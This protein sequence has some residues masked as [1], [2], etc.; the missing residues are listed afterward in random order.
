M[1][2]DR[3]Q[4]IKALAKKRKRQPV[5]KQKADNYAKSIIKQASHISKL[6]CDYV[7]Q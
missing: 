4:L 7:I 2:P 5:T 1:N 6:P 3:L